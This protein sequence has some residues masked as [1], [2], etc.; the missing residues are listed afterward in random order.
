MPLVTPEPSIA[1]ENGTPAGSPTEREARWVPWLCLLILTLLYF[2]PTCVRAAKDKLWFDEI[3]TFDAAGLLPHYGQ[4]WTALKET[5]AA[6]PVEFVAAWL[7]ESVFG[8]NEFGLRFPSVVAFWL[9]ALCLYAFLKRRIPWQ[10]AMAAMPLA[11]L[12]AAGPYAWEGRPYA[13]MLAFGAAA[14]LAWQRA[15]ENRHR[16]TALP[17]LACS[18]GGALL[19]HT[20]AVA[21]ALPLAAGEIAR[22]FKRKRIDW[23]VWLAFALSTPALIVLWK[24]K[25]ASDFGPFRHFTGTVPGHIAITYLQMLMPAVAPLALTLLLAG[26]LRRRQASASG[27]TATLPVYE[28]V[29]VA[30]FALI[31]FVAVP[32]S[33]LADR[34]WLRY[35]LNCTI[36]IV[37]LLILLI[38]R[39]GG[40]NRLAGVSALAVFST[41]FA[42]GQFLP[43]DRRPDWGLKLVNSSADILPVFDQLPT[44]A[45]IVICSDLVFVELEHYLKPE[46]AAR[47]YYLTDRASA[48]AI[49]GDTLFEVRG[50]LIQKFF[51]F[52]ANFA[53]YHAFVATHKRFYVV[54]PIR[55]IVRE[56]LAGRMDLKAVETPSH[57]QYYVATP[58]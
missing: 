50:S 19:T 45:P 40:R 6:P 3:Y 34:Y 53:D 22:T 52:H 37:G 8:R 12:T 43:E 17:V 48:A 44:D 33:L 27:T 16:W 55:N 14:L 9:M 51:P 31:P 5:E 36:G 11:C 7:S 56:Y 49:D 26:L 29:A 4:F 35:S 25:V 30:A 41:A 13:I 42:I 47:L 58:R 57:F 28:S 21:L 20:M 39:I 1:D 15:A 46:Q 38:Y 23:P 10:F 54:R 2:V 24:I 32:L 18:L